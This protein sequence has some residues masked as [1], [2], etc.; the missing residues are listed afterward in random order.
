MLKRV[1]LS[2]TIMSDFFIF[3]FCSKEF[4]EFYVVTF[5]ARKKSVFTLRSND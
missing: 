5:I 2:G 3:F 4:S 1:F